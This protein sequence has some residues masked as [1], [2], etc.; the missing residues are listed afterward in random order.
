MARVILGYWQ[1][2]LIDN[3]NVP[4]ESIGETF[5]MPEYFEHGNKHR[6]FMGWDGIFIF[7]P[8]APVMDMVR[9]YVHRIQEGSC[10][11]C[12]PCRIGTKLVED[13]LKSIADGLGREEDLTEIR[14]LGEVIRDASMCEWG[15]TS[16]NALLKI[17]ELMPEVFEQPLKDRRPVPRG[18]YH[19]A[20][21]APCMEA[22]PAHLDIPAYIDSIRSG[23]YHDSLRVIQERNPLP[24]ICGR[25]CVAPCESACRREELDDPIAIR[26]LK[27]FASDQIQ[28]Y[29]TIRERKLEPLPITSDK[30]VAIIGA[31]PCGLTAAFYLRQKGHR[32]E[33]FEDLF[34]PGGMSAVGIPDYRLPREVIKAEVDRIADIGVQFHYGVR[35]GR[36]KS[37]KQLRS[38][39]D[40]VLIA[41]GAH[42][43]KK[44][45][46]AGEELKPMGLIPGVT[47]LRQIALLQPKGEF[48]PPEGK[49][50][51]VI[52]GGNVAMDCARSARRLGYP[53]VSLVYR[54]T[55]KEMPANVVEVREAK[56]EGIEFQVLTHPVK[57]EARDRKVTGLTCVRMELSEPDASGRQRPVEV[58][59]SGFLLDCD[60][61]IPAIGQSTE[62]SMFKEDFPVKLTKWGTVEVNED[63]LMSCQDGVFSGGDCV[64]GPKV[65]IEAMRQG[66]HAA[67]SIDLY[68]GGKKMTEPENY[69]TFR[70]IKSMKLPEVPADRV[71]KNP[72]IH[73]E[74]R[75]PEERIGDFGEV[76]SSFTPEQ[77]MAEASRCLRCY[78]LGMYMTEE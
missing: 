39:F 50:V 57:L 71:G 60:V 53:K 22:C 54:R 21:T 12:S 65:L 18:A 19:S 30:R 69:H 36:D 42:G 58:K 26:F 45:G 7:D 74:M 70:M 52:G 66:R 27:R 32:V 35:I 63:T 44:V 34:E 47:F 55:E 33:V 15:Q 41:I 48:V 25:V 43:W 37:L 17:M 75:P 61:V 29:V 28:S 2:K 78:R 3:R 64:T 38:E 24:G 4:A 46:M 77:A 8:K 23:N 6:A 49:H 9:E 10:G 73:P 76:E 62:T 59:D 16:M 68:L 72:Q 67:Y 20:T 5:P 31:G 11:Q 51:V 1:G 56:E 40:A 14:Q 13:K